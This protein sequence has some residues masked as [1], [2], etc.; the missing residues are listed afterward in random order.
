MIY[1][2]YI[3][4]MLFFLGKKK[5]YFDFLNLLPKATTHFTTNSRH[6][7]D[8]AAFFMNVIRFS[9]FL[10]RKSLFWLHFEHEFALLIW[11]FFNEEKMLEN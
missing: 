9:W 2:H 11:N 1:L 6:A 7:T 4:D 8:P 3:D 10:K 5:K